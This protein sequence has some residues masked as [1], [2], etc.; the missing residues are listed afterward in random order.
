[1]LRELD[2]TK[3]DLYKFSVRFLVQVVKPLRA[4]A[5]FVNKGVGRKIPKKANEKKTEK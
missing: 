2:N 1:M 5:T 4:N 3:L